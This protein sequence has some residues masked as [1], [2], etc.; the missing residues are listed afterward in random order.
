MRGRELAL[1]IFAVLACGVSSQYLVLGTLGVIPFNS[2]RD[3]LLIPSLVVVWA[4][5][6]YARYAE[7]RLANRLLMGLVSGL[8]ATIGLEI[9]R[10]PGYAI[11]HWLP[12][13]DM[14][15]FPGVLLT[16]TAGNMMGAMPYMDLSQSTPLLA[17]LVGGLWHFWNGATFGAVYAI[18]LGKVKW[19]HGVI[20]GLIIEVGMMLAPWMTMDPMMGPFGVGYASG[21]NIFAVTLMGHVAYGSILGI[22]AWRLVKEEGSILTLLKARS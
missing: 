5:A 9:F 8:I 20:W 19:W 13:D 21:Y 16:G 2:Y 11:I 22:L 17:L 4:I 15:A 7:K 12:G 1:T 18:L 14:M 3:L 6:V 10:I